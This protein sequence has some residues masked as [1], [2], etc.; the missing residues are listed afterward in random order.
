[1]KFIT[2]EEFIKLSQD[3]SSYR[4][5]TIELNNLFEQRVWEL[6]DDDAMLILTEMSPETNRVLR[7]YIKDKLGGK[8]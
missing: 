4:D 2:E 6:I 5:A 7:A 3:S 1:M 8:V